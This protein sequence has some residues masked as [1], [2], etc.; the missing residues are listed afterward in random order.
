[1]KCFMTLQCHPCPYL[2]SPTY[3]VPMSTNGVT[4]SMAHPNLRSEHP[5][6]CQNYPV[7][8]QTRPTI[9]IQDYQRPIR[10]IAW[11]C[12]PSHC[13]TIPFVPALK[14][15]YHYV[16]HDISQIEKSHQPH[17][18]LISLLMPKTTLIKPNGDQPF[19]SLTTIC[20]E[21]CK[22]H[23]N[24][25]HTHTHTL[26]L[27]YYHNIFWAWLNMPSL[28]WPRVWQILQNIQA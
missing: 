10:G 1:M 14:P 19:W 5:L 3:G 8:A 22:G 20:I 11:I 25:T 24:D 16:W 7:E 27:W 21:K 15:H 28:C 23:G 13:M 2:L 26:L 12:Q 17:W 4:I 18:S 6:S 9:L